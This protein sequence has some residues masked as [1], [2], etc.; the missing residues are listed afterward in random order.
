MKHKV[1]KIGITAA[2]LVLA[3]SGLLWSTLREGTEYY[4]HVDEVMANPEAWQGK[5]LQLHGFVVR[6]SILRKRDSF[7]YRFQVQNKGRIV[8]AHYTG[9]VPDTFAD[10]AEV[11]LKG[12]LTPD[13]FH[14]APNGVMAKCPSKYEPKKG[15]AAP[16]A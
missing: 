16:G 10:D 1:L 6:D 11:V 3:L 15:A 7:D 4:K 12:T 2:V 9:I 8:A 5:R 14:V 13:G